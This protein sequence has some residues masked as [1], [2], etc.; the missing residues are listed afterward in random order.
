[1]K[2]AGTEWSDLGIVFFF[3]SSVPAFFISLVFAG[4]QG[5]LTSPE[6]VGTSQDLLVLTLKK[7]MRPLLARQMVF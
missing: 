2:N 7:C 4:P 6:N 3:F 1:M 5:L